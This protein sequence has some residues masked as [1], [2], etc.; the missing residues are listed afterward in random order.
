MYKNKIRHIDIEE[1]HIR[2]ISDILYP[3]LEE[4]IKKI[5]FDLKKYIYE[6]PEFLSSL[7]PLKHAFL[8]YAK[9]NFADVSFIFVDLLNKK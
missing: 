7:E 8:I 3:N 1:T 2:L 6:N 4:Y 9:S 5:R